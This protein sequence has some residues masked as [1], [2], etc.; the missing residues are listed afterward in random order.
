M[1]AH[2]GIPPSTLW[3]VESDR[4]TLSYDKLQMLSQ[5]LDMSM[6]ELFAEPTDGAE[7]A[8]TGRR[9]IGRV[10]DAVRVNTPNYEYHYLCPD[11]RHKHMI[12]VYTRVRAKS[13][14]Q[15]GALVRHAGEEYAYILQGRVVLHTEF[16][17][18]VVLEAGQ[19]VYIDASMGHAFLA[20]EGCEEALMLFVC[21]SAAESFVESL[22]TSHV[23]ENAAGPSAGKRSS[24]SQDYDD[25]ADDRT[26][27]RRVSPAL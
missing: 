6:S 2:S 18:P 23:E 9:S 21:S 10:E 19:S 11:L 7:P 14:E 3:K 20:G 8:V 26:R 22:L 25:K 5:R 13:I 24:V 12:P 17:N 16:W 27:S 15:F 1:S 4:L